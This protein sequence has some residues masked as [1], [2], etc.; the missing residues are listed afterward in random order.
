MD[1]DPPYS[2][3]P[4]LVS[5]T[6]SDQ[7]QPT[8]GHDQQMAP[9][10][11]DPSTASGTGPTTAPPALD[12]LISIHEGRSNQAPTSSRQPQN[13]QPAVAALPRTANSS[14]PQTPSLENEP[15]ARSVSPR[16]ARDVFP[17]QERPLNVTDAMRYLDSVKT[18]FHDRPEVYNRFLDIMK[19][20]KSAVID[21][22]GVIERV[23]R[24]F[25]ANQDLVRGFNTFLP[26]GYFIEAG[27][28]GYITVHSP[29]GTS[30]FSAVDPTATFQPP[31]NMPT[32]MTYHNSLP[33]AE[34]PQG[35]NSTQSR[36][37]YVAPAAMNDVSMHPSEPNEDKQAQYQKAIQFVNK[38]K[39][40]LAGEPETYKTFLEL[41]QK[42]GDNDVTVQQQIH[43]LLKGAP[44]L[45]A[46]IKEF[47]HDAKD[48]GLLGS[49]F[50]GN[51]IN[52]ASDWIAAHKR[53][54]ASSSLAPPPAKRKKK[55][56]EK[57]P[58]PSSKPPSSRQKKPKHHH[59]MDPLGDEYMYDHGNGIT[60]LG[61]GSVYMSAGASTSDDQAFFDR[62]KK[63]LDNRET[64]DEFL[65]L[66][67][68][69]SQDIIDMRTLVEK[70]NTFLGD[71]TDLTIQFRRIIGWDERE[72][73]VR[74]PDDPS[75]IGQLNSAIY[76]PPEKEDLHHKCGPSYRR[77]PANEAHQAC[78][79]RDELCRSVLNDEW[80]SHPTWASEDNSG[81]QAHKKNVFEEALHKCEEER[82]EFDFH[83]E[84]M[85][86]T[87]SALENINVKIQQMSNEEKS[88]FKLK[89]GLGLTNKSF[90]QRIIKKV[91]GRDAGLEVIA[92]LHDCPAISVP[93]ILS[94]LKAKDDDWRR[95]QREWNKVWREIDA[96]N[97]YKALDHQGV[98]FKSTD[99]K[100][101]TTKALVG[102][103]EGA[104]D[105]QLSQRASLTD[106]S[107]AKT[108]PTYQLAYAITDLT[109]M[110]D[111]TKLILSY[112]DRLSTSYTVAER[113]KIEKWIISFLVTFF[114]LDKADFEDSLKTPGQV[115]DASGALGVTNMVPASAVAPTMELDAEEPEVPPS[116]TRTPSKGKGRSTA[117]VNG[118]ET[119]KS[120]FPKSGGTSRV[121]SAKPSPK[122][123][124]TELPL[125]PPRASENTTMPVDNVWIGTQPAQAEA[126]TSN[127]RSTSTSEKG[128][129]ANRKASFFGN[130][131]TY[132]VLR[133][134]ETL[135]SRLLLCK[136]ITSHL[137]KAEGTHLANSLAVELGLLEGLGPGSMNLFTPN[138]DVELNAD[139]TPVNPVGRFYD[140]LLECCENLFA[141][142]MDQNTFEENLRF[143]F[144]TK[145]Y[146]LFTVDKVIAALI[147]QVH[148]AMSDPQTEEL[149]DL[150]KQERR[151]ES[152]T[153]QQV[154]TYRRS[155][156]DIIGPDDSLFRINWDHT[157]MTMQLLGKSD[158][159]TDDAETV[160]QRWRFY[161]ESY[162]L[163]HP[164][165]GVQEPKKMPFLRRNVVEA[166][167][168][169]TGCQAHNGLE[170][171][172]CIRTYR[173]F[174]SSNTEDF[175]WRYGDGARKQAMERLPDIEKKRKETFETW[176]ETQRAAKNKV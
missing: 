27:L 16:S 45:Q 4:P 152:P 35:S 139:G 108:R 132:V 135:Y 174:F 51:V 22:P 118:S 73:L 166:P 134:F 160:A 107:L 61:G 162:V 10:H 49:V 119:R 68:M 125:S 30:H 104:R 3:Q 150:L 80:V 50:A 6:V 17:A 93:I 19:D 20:F 100:A 130:T 69:F 115:N 77:I 43:T 14:A 156:E 23:S 105:E 63:A 147:K 155:A 154:I 21:T 75:S 44:D 143:M 5:S 47:W 95:A 126:P 42:Y 96:R 85:T 138:A 54:E 40:R 37:P 76:V 141:G 11:P 158:P 159:S 103:I 2:A 151:V 78:S 38:I 168:T 121:H 34:F 83:L 92:A 110:K 24:L 175:F 142:D 55:L 8:S 123:N 7:P 72:R 171:R 62:V 120:L 165:E 167:L 66:L 52:N 89:P 99:K 102:A 82:H 1:T 161:I 36:S 71:S 140:H 133:I 131:L 148:I 172:V 59:R 58:A 18:R 31:M 28:N 113:E 145:G 67:N 60:G 88:T 149:L 101:M 64:F 32:N 86:K 81:Y 97:F 41:I 12:M 70:A 65:K 98:S 122:P 124:A 117:G 163:T 112:L 39:N 116:G 29:H 56:P 57:E 176:L 84:I 9:T 33:P 87:I 111:T 128:P 137:V 136:E 74:E 91:Y 144:G 90:Y 170:I 48:N 114:V 146:L 25:A 15:P 79:G 169:E 164:T 157:I 173:L 46:E 94:R 106:P 153:T 26:V 129:A 13:F 109:V 127:T 53:K